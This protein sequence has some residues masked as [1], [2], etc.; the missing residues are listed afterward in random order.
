MTIVIGQPEQDAIIPGWVVDLES[1]RRWA[2]SGEFPE[3]G[4][5]SHLD[6]KLWVDFSMERLGHNE[7][8]TE[9][10]AC[11]APLARDANLGKFYCD[12]MLLTH[13]EAGIS[14]EPDGMYV[15]YESLKSG[16][17]VFKKGLDSLE[18]IGT[19]DMVLEVVSPTS[20]R[21]DT[22]TL[23]RLYHRAGIPEYWLVD[24]I[25]PQG[26]FTFDI[27][28]WTSRGYV[29]AVKQDGWVKSHVFKRGFRLIRGIDPIGETTYRVE[30][31]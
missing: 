7:I 13:V 17:L 3:S 19:P 2:Y 30:Q 28:R 5:F 8:K 29:A 9:F 21:K 4:Q 31:R 25:P 14:T 1:F 22:V 18:A 26:Q 6:G 12:G 10:T 24:R 11:L 16:K 27:L 23:R 20:R 15:S